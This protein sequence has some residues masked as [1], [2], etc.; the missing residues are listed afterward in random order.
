M[1]RWMIAVVGAASIV[2]GVWA[3]QQNWTQHPSSAEQEAE[4]RTA[5][6][7]QLEGWARSTRE[8]LRAQGAHDGEGAVLGL[9]RD[10]ALAMPWLKWMPVNAER[11][12]LKIEL[13]YAWGQIK[14]GHSR[15]ALNEEVLAQLD[16]A[17]GEFVTAARTLAEREV[18]TTWQEPAGRPKWVNTVLGAVLGGAL[19]AV[20][21]LLPVTL[22]IE[23]KAWRKAEARDTHVISVGTGGPDKRQ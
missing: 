21:L 15:G 1:K 20:A 9:E 23:P 3:H 8:T 18:H 17:L 11:Y 2:G 6:A 14:R 12:R 19:A 7:E 22:G 16:D 10:I 5:R 4:G 13:Q